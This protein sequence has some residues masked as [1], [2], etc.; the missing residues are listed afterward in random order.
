M[1]GITPMEYRNDIA[2]EKLYASRNHNQ[3][4]HTY[5]G[6]AA[7]RSQVDWNLTLR[8][9]RR[10]AKQINASASEPELHTRDLAESRAKREPLAPGHP[11]GEY[12]C[13]RPSLGRYQNFANSSHMINGLT[14]KSSGSAHSVDWQLNLRNEM[15]QNEFQTKWKRH[16]ARPQQS[17]DMMA[18]NCSKDNEAYQNSQITPQDRRPDRRNGAISI[19]NIR[20]DPVSFRRWPGAEG[21]QVNAWRHLIEDRSRGYK[22]RGHLAYEVTLRQDEK[23]TNGA[24]IWDNRSDGC[25][26]EMMGKKKW[27]GHVHHDHMSQREPGPGG[28][29]RD[30]KLYHL[31]QQRILPEPDEDNREKRKAKQPR[32]DANI[33]ERREPMSHA[34]QTQQQ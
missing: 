33:P 34:N 20:A 21:T 30:P 4:R 7:N 6:A 13:E 1:A 2:G 14:R 8:Q 29:L 32:T 3:L 18:E 27:V 5:S 11:D 12:H 19:A 16:Y 9:V 24:R 15:H 10:P 22:A 28:R 31:A 26:V 25:I 23:D 17:F